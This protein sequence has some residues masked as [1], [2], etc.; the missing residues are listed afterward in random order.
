M[1]I[2][3]NSRN[4][5]GNKVPFTTPDNYFEE[6]SAKIEQLLD[7]Q[8]E[9]NQVINLSLWQRVQPYVYLAAMFIGLY[10]SMTTFVKPSI[11]QKQ[12]EQELV[13]LAIQKELLLDEIDDY[14]L[15]ELLSYNN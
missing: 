4:E 9:S 6:F 15:Y 2:N 10:V 3:D 14:A 7:K 12:K 1:E 8:E 5:V 11:Q 13:E